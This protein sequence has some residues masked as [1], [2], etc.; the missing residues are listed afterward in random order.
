MPLVGGGGAPNVSGGSNPAGTG[1]S[2]N[3]IGNHCYAYSGVVTPGGATSADTTALKFTTGNSYAM[4]EVNWTCMSTSATVDQYF[5]M[6][7]D[8]QIIFNARAEDDE[9]ATAQSP[10]KVLLPPFTAVEIKVGDAASNDMSVIL[11]GRV[12]A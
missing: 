2:L 12:Y 9:T 6:I 8:S 10:I 1:S 11:A 5:Q 3:Y 7:M 4:V